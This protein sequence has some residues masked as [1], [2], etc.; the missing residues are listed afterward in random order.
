MGTIAQTAGVVQ[1]Q[2]LLVH[3]CQEYYPWLWPSTP[4]RDCQPYASKPPPLDENDV[5]QNN[6]YEGLYLAG[7]PW[8]G[9]RPRR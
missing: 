1:V 3:K 8:R 5:R 7:T 9:V 2:L 4:G 6:E